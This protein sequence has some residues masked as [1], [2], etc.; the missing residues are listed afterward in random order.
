MIPKYH[1]GYQFGFPGGWLILA[2]SGFSYL[3]RLTPAGVGGFWVPWKSKGD[4]KIMIFNKNGVFGTKS[5][6]REGFPKKHVKSMK[7]GSEN[8]MFWDGKT[9]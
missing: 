2:E 8:E 6:L 5:A 3:Q 9:F 7:K 1:F 4:P